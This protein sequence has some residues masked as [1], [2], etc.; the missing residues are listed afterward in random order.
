MA[1]SN[2]I[3]YCT[4]LQDRFLQQYYHSI[5]SLTVKIHFVAVPPAIVLPTRFKVVGTQPWPFEC[6]LEVEHLLVFN[7]HPITSMQ[8]F[9]WKGKKFPRFLEVLRNC[10]VGATNTFSG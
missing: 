4:I 9:T 6:Q 5:H 7:G 2:I 10:K 3:A 8:R 1:H